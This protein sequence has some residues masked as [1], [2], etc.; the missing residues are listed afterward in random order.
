MLLPVVH[1]TQFNASPG[2]R[3]A[4]LTASMDRTNH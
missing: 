3:G 4:L 1:P 2:I